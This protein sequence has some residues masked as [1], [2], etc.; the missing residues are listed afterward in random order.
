MSIR[1]LQFPARPRSFAVVGASERERYVELVLQNVMRASFDGPVRPV[2]PKHRT[3]R[4]LHCFRNVKALPEAPDKPFR[5]GPDRREAGTH[6]LARRAGGPG[7]PR[8]SAEGRAAKCRDARAARRGLTI[9]VGLVSRTGR[10]VACSVL[11]QRGCNRRSDRS[12]RHPP[13]RCRRRPCRPDRA[14]SEGN[15]QRLPSVMRSRSR[16]RGICDPRP[17]RP[18]GAGIGRCCIV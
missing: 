12:A 14:G 17:H 9:P 15:H 6:L 13:E 8:H 11:T 18:A 10:I 3:V 4:G 16:A 2:N 7:R 1:N 5:R